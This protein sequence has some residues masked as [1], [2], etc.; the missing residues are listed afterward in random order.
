[1]AADEAGIG[2]ASVWRLIVDWACSSLYTEGRKGLVTRPVRGSI[3][4]GSLNDEGRSGD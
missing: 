4:P 1:M 2:L 3:R